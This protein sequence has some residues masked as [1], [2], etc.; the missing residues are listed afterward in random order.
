MAMARNPRIEL[1]PISAHLT[2]GPLL[3]RAPAGGPSYRRIMLTACA[4]GFLVGLLI[5]AALGLVLVQISY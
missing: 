3:R 5:L 1:T 2:S 4:L